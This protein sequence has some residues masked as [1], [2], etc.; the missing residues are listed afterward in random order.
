MSAPLRLS[1]RDARRICVRAQLL[2]DP[3]PASV[4]DV[5]RDLFMVQMDPTRVVARTEHLVLFSRLGR[6]FRV[7]DLERRLWVDKT[8]FEYHAF[9]MPTADYPIHREEMRAYPP[10]DRYA[11]HRYVREWLAENQG[12][13]RYVLRELRRRGPLRSRDLENRVVWGWQTGGWN[14]DGNDVPMMLELLWRRG[15]VMIV[16]RDGQQ[17]LWD[18]AERR[19]PVREP[20]LRPAEVAAR[21]AERQLRAHGVARAREIG[22]TF[23]GPTVGRE[24]A[25]ADLVRGGVAV[26]ARIDDVA[27][28]WFAHRDVLERPWRPRSVLLSPFDRLVHDRDRTEA[29]FD[30]FYRLEIYVPRAQRRWGYFVLPILHGD[31]LIGRIDPAY[32]REDRVLKINAVFAE[33]HAPPSAGPAVGRAITELARWLG[34][35]DIAFI[36]RAAVA[37]VWR[38][39]LAP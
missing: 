34:A 13:R 15:E 4:D 3:R 12:F 24:R 28:D 8:L 36:D 7:E 25:L 27:G 31:R 11:R 39:A 35:H 1:R 5:V 37:P 21:I 30:F 6:R 26:P 14:D 29:L 2:S 16:G 20:R 18:L 33:E 17:R 19:L 22:Q 10:E 23:A 38:R 32:D 9:I